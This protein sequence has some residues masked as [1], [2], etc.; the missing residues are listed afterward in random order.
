MRRFRSALIC[1]A[2]IGRAAVVLLAKPRPHIAHPQRNEWTEARRK[3]LD[4]IVPAAKVRSWRAF[5]SRTATVEVERTNDTF[6][7][8]P[9]RALEKPHGAFK[10][11]LAR[12]KELAY[13][14]PEDL[15]RAILQ[16]FTVATPA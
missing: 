5:I 11:D 13:P 10:A 7:V 15:G 16:A 2:Q 1:P 6:T 9:M 14:P 12:E 3:S 4:P 8:T